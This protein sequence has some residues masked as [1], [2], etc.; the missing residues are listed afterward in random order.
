MDPEDGRPHGSQP[1]QIHVV[2]ARTGHVLMYPACTYP[3]YCRVAHKQRQQHADKV[4]ARLIRKRAGST[5]GRLQLGG[6]GA[7]A[8]LA[9]RSSSLPFWSSASGAWMLSRMG[10][11]A[12]QAT[13]SQPALHQASTFS[14]RREMRSGRHEGGQSCS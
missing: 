9:A 2:L 11:V 14:A 13:D 4:A 1:A 6:S 8:C 5:D 3:S 12:G 7:G 10:G